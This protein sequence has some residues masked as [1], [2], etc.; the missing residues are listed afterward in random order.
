MLENNPDV[1]RI[2]P[3]DKKA[4][5]NPFKALRY[6]ARIGRSGYDLIV[7]FQQL[8]R[9][10]YVIMFSDA[11]VKLTTRPPW[12]NKFFYTHWSDPV[13]AYAA[14]CKAGVLGPLG[15]EW[16]GEPPR[17]WLT[18]E[19]T[20]WAGDFITREGMTPGR[21]I[22]VDPSHR[23]ITRKWPERHFAGLIKL[24]REKHP[25]L[26]AFILYGPGEKGVADEVVRLAGDGAVVSDHM[27][28]LREMA[29]VQAQCR[30]APGQLL[31]P[32]ALRR[33]R[34]HPLPDHPRGHRVRLVLP[35]GEAHQ[36]GQGT[37][38][39]FLQQERMRNQGMPGDLPPR[40]MFGRGASA[41]GIQA[42]VS[43]PR[44]RL[45]GPNLPTRPSGYI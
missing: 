5:K 36:R 24:L 23:R 3:I 31:R 34:G 20:A 19:E 16:N 21:F 22:T 40:G 6:Y 30:P 29:A 43:G 4:L 33:G 45:P 38:V 41:P 14:K 26:Q 1:A 27:L 18:D 9:C 35:V 10:R 25:D 12:Y 8:P 11:E 2:W 44:P 15:I 42:A 17:I 37:P 39:P 32:E 28:S 7:D 13:F